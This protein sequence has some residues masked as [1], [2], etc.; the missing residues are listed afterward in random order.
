MAIY[1]LVAGFRPGDA[2]SNEA[3]CLQ[4]LFRSWGHESAIYT[5]DRNARDEGHGQVRPLSSL[6]DTATSDDVVWLHLSTGS[7]VNIAFGQVP[8]KKVVLYHNMTPPE[9]FK[10][11]QEYIVHALERG[12][13]QARGLHDKADVALACSTFS[14]KELTELGYQNVRVLPFVTPRPS[15]GGTN[16]RLLKKLR[17]GKKNIL[18][19]G[20]GAP[21]K[22]IEDL[23]SAFY[24]YQ[25]FVEPESR[26]IH[27][28]SF[29]GTEVY[30]A[31]VTTYAHDLDLDHVLMKGGVPGEDLKAYY[32]AADLFLCMSEHEGFC[33]PL[34]ESMW[35]DVPVLAYAAAA[36]PETMDGAG[37][38]VKEKQFDVIGEMM[39]RMTH[40]PSLKQTILEGQQA[41]MVRY[42]NLRLDQQ[43]RD[44]IESLNSP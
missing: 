41:R 37:V 21:N 39:G 10:G 22:R 35:H 33:V 13:R 34:L 36:V 12:Q 2:I 43:V 19:V 9:F 38:L 5:E 8:G 17:D 18:F 44:I 31:L 20:R 42:E 16:Q 23:V 26:L 32:K 4:E 14:A 1:Q 27:I 6:R 15:N 29:A 11:V 28:G 7:P 3:V 30:R 24:Y 40:D 25:K